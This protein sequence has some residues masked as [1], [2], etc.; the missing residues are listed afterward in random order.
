MDAFQ[1]SR[2]TDA[3]HLVKQ[4]K[5]E[6]GTNPITALLATFAPYCQEVR[7]SQTFI[8]LLYQE[9]NRVALYIVQSY[10]LKS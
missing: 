6:I 1:D 5:I 3:D 9:G 2:K 8:P 7:L 10:N 4:H